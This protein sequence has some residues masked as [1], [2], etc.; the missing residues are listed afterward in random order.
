MAF[1]FLSLITPISFGYFS[2]EYC[3]LT[4]KL[5]LAQKAH[6]DDG[7]LTNSGFYVAKFPQDGVYQRSL[8][9]VVFLHRV[10]QQIKGSDFRHMVM[11]IKSSIVYF[12]IWRQHAYACRARYC[13]GKSFLPSVCPRRCVMVSKLCHV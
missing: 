13:Y 10:I 2:Y 8:K 1:Y 12:F 4:L 9:S 5:M 11:C 6:C 7:I 3:T